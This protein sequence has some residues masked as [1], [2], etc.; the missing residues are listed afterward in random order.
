MSWLKNMNTLH[1][2][3][4]GFRFTGIR[5]LHGLALGLVI[6]VSGLAIPNSGKA[7]SPH[8][9]PPTTD[10]S[11]DDP[12]LICEKGKW[13]SPMNIFS[14]TLQDTQGDLI[15]RYAPTNIHVVHDGHSVQA[16]PKTPVSLMCILLLPR[17][18][19]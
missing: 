7:G 17:W 4:Y 10:R 16:I 12:Y 14:T 19:S 2:T 6:H 18:K 3:R 9:S 8:H 13:Q 11:H 15:F 5:F 1:V